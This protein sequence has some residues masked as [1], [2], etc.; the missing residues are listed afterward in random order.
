MHSCALLAM[1]A[2]LRLTADHSDAP[3]DWGALQVFVS[4]CRA[5]SIAAAS[6]ALGINHS[7]VLRRV[8]ALESAAGVKLFERTPGGYVLTAAGKDLLQG[9]AG[10][11]ERIDG[12]TRELHGTDEE[13]KG[14]IRVTT[15]DTLLHGLL[16]P[17]LDAFGTRHPAVTLRL[18]VNNAFM[19]LSR[20]EADIAIR[21]S[22]R[23]PEN[24][25]GRRVGN[26]QTAPYAS[27]AFLERSGRRR[28][29]AQLDWV[30]FDESLAHLEAAAWLFRHVDRSRIVFTVDSLVVLVQAVRQGIGAGMLLC[31]LAD[32][33]PELVRLAEPEPS[34]DTQL[35]ILTHPDLRQVARMRAFAQFMF[36]A[37]SAEPRLVH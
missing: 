37:L 27:R 15:T 18:V 8:A 32:A 14:L 17:H 1:P 7:T 9:L 22:N 30:G 23:P 33:H 2:R 31:P 35:W 29:L 3:L 26:I 28:Q 12:T 21:G 25:V 24:L 20:R 4:V 16:L 5:G 10:V 11:G 13:V 19:S 36:D 6:A 34:H